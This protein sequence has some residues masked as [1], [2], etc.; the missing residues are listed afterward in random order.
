MVLCV[1][2]RHW[3]DPRG[4]LPTDNAALRRKALRVVQLIEA[5]ALLE[6]GEFREALVACTKRL[7]G[8]ACDGL[9]WVEK[10]SDERLHAY[11]RVCA[12][13][14]LYISG[15][16]DTRWSEGPMV[17]MSDPMAAVLHNIN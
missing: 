13:E 3:L 5:G 8:H 4:E 6:P 14:E 10:C 11:C 2:I 12:R 9:L 16:Q 7:A 17:P 15:W 1:D